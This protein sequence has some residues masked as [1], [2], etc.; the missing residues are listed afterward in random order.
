M[1]QRDV[2]SSFLNGDLKEKVY[3]EQPPRFVLPSSKGKVY[4]LKKAYYRMKQAPR[5]WYQ[6]I[7]AYFLRRGF[8]RSPSNTNLYII[9]EGEKCMILILYVDDII[10]TRNHD[11]KIDQI[12]GMLRK[13]FVMKSVGLIHSCLGIECGRIH[14]R[15]SSLRKSMLGRH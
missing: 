14:I 3:V 8:R 1:Y 13:E 5:A 12:K 4:K 10:M 9:I 6:Q 15:S 11:E 7:D 2:K